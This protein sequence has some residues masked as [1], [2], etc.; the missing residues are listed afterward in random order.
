MSPGYTAEQ[1]KSSFVFHL[2]VQAGDGAQALVHT[3][4]LFTEAQPQPF[5]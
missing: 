5:Y 3:W 1:P 2:C 4:Q